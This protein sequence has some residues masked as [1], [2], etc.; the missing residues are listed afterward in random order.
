M[1]RREGNFFLM[2]ENLKEQVERMPECE[3]LAQPQ[4]RGSDN[5]SKA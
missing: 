5:G 1:M 3:N 2:S 4:G